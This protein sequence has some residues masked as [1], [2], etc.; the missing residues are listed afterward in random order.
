MSAESIAG[1]EL[2]ARQSDRLDSLGPGEL[3]LFVPQRQLRRR[4]KPGRLRPDRGPGINADFDYPPMWHN[5]YGPLYLDRPN[6]SGFDGYWVTPWRFSVGLQA[7]AE[8]GAPLNRM[9]YYNFF[10]GAGDLSGPAR[11]TAGRSAA[12]LGSE[13]LAGLSHR[14][15][16]PR[17]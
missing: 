11:G 10:T 16:A 7:F 14:R 3:C 5:A 15:S 2:F 8:T 17:P 4:R 12:P 1:L 9:G 6:R 13:I